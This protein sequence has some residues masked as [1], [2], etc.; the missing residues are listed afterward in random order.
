[1]LLVAAEHGDQRVAAAVPAGIAP[2][3]D[4]FRGHQAGRPP[5]PQGTLNMDTGPGDPPQ[6]RALGEGRERVQPGALRREVLLAAPTL[7]AFR[8]GPTELRRAVLRIDGGQDHPRHA[9]VPLQ[10]HHL[11]ELPARAGQ[12]PHPQA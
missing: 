9:A 6:R 4:G 8:C 2:A 10:L 1:M 5:Y 7:H 11:A 3:E 12:R